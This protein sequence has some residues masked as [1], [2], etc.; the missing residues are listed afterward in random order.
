MAKEGRGGVK[1]NFRVKHELLFQLLIFFRPS[2]SRVVNEPAATALRG[3]VGR[4]KK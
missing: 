3:S 1:M 4:V 2:V